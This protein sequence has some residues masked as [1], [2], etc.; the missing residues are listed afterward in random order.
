MNSLN[1]ESHK[2]PSRVLEKIGQKISN[3]K[4]DIADNIERR[5]QMHSNA[6]GNQ[7]HFTSRTNT[8]DESLVIEK[9]PS[10]PPE[11]HPQRASSKNRKRER[12]SIYLHSIREK[13]KYGIFILSHLRMHSKTV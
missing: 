13:E 4:E 5:R 8:I 9:K 11:S 1:N 10:T 12:N 3:I 7:M 2:K 6:N